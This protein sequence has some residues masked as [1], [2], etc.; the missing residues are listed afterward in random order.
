LLIEGLWLALIGTAAGVALGIAF[1]RVVNSLSLPIPFPIALHLSPDRA[2]FVCALGLVILTVLLCALLPSVNATRMTLV[3]ALKKEE[4]FYLMRRF[5]ARGVL[6]TGQVTVSTVLLVTAFLFV[7]NLVRT[8]VT[9]PGFEVNHA[10]VAQIGFVRGRPDADHPA[11]LE[12]AVERARSLPGIAAAAYAGAIPLTAHGGSTSGLSARLG[13]N[14]TPQHV[15]F[16]RAV[17]GPG[18]F[19]TLNVRLLAGREFDR[20]DGPG[21]PPVAIINEEFSRRYFRGTNPIGQRLQFVDDSIIYQIVGVVGNGK[22]R[23]LGEDQRAALYL[24]L[25]QRPKLSVAFVVMRTQRDPR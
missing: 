23:T 1:M 21:T 24:P 6:L 3:P 25:R 5:T 12:A 8:Q 10:L 16:A 9:N 11:F 20:T 2:V 22:H 7:R 13:D 4:P 14:A 15:E 19:S 17:V 18:Y